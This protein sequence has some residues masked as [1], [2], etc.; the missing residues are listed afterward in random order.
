[1]PIASH[2]TARQ[3]QNIDFLNPILLSQ[4]SFVTETAI[5]ITHDPFAV[6]HCHLRQFLIKFHHYLS[7]KDAK[8]VTNTRNLIETLRI[9]PFYDHFAF[10]RELFLTRTIGVL[11]VKS[12]A[13]QPNVSRLNSIWN[14]F[15]LAAAREW[16]RAT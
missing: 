3:T 10:F 4:Q 1:M 2:T 11:C 14:V 12:S 13:N 7:S 9:I 5:D 8:L 16:S 15:F 6:P